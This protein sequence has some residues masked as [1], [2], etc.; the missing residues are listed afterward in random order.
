[1][2]HNRSVTVLDFRP[3]WRGASQTLHRIEGQRNEK[4]SET[5]SADW[6]LFFFPHRRNTCVDTFAVLSVFSKEALF[7][8]YNSDT[9]AIYYFKYPPPD[10]LKWCAHHQHAASAW[11][12]N[13]TEEHTQSSWPGAGAATGKPETELCLFS[14]S[15][16]VLRSKPPIPFHLF[17]PKALSPSPPFCVF[18]RCS[19]VCLD[20]CVD[21]EAGWSVGGKQPLKWRSSRGTLQ[22]N[23]F[24][25]FPRMPFQ[26]MATVSKCIL[27][28]C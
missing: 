10:P 9:P 8:S 16:F 12:M 1:M 15:L 17:A 28:P 13:E 20:S 14:L 4:L 21:K 22:M 3:G 6:E 25:M 2:S 11:P 5:W 24:E 27:P 7:M 23:G 19:V 26:L 18:T